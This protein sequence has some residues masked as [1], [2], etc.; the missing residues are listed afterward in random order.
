MASNGKAT[1]SEEKV[2]VGERGGGL[3]QFGRHRFLHALIHRAVVPQVNAS[4]ADTSEDS[5]CVTG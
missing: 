2:R 5:P 1:R 4:V 3:R